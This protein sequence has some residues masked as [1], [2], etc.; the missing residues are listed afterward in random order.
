MDVFGFEISK[1]CLNLKK[2]LIMS[3][4][5]KNEFKK[6]VF[7][8]LQKK[9]KSIPSKYFYNKKGLNYLIKFAV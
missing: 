6:D 5:F 7:E 1:R 3:I 2:V 9:N 8:G 4:K